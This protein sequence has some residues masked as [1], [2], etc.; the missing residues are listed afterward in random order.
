MNPELLA[1]AR[2]LH[3]HHQGYAHISHKLAGRGVTL[4]PDQWCRVL[5][6]RSKNK[7]KPPA[8]VEKR[9]PMSVARGYRAAL[10]AGVD[11]LE[12]RD[13]INECPHGRLPDYT[14]DSCACWRAA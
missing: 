10:A 1:Y 6:G 4:T 8:K 3:A 2:K 14:G 11:P 9:E 12:W 13:A 5:G 7:P